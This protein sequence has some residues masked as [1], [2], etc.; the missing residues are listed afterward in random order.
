[1]ELLEDGGVSK[2]I[3]LNHVVLPPFAV[4]IGSVQ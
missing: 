3:D 4:F 2:T 1:M